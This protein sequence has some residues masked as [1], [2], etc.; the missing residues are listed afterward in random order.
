[1]IGR[2]HGNPQ[3]ISKGKEQKEV[4][5]GQLLV[6]GSLFELQI[7]SSE[8][9]ISQNFFEAT[10]RTAHLLLPGP[11]EKTLPRM[12]ESLPPADYYTL[13]IAA[14]STAQRIEVRGTRKDLK[15]PGLKDLHA[16]GQSWGTLPMR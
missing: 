16:C 15:G 13:K 2:K 6:P 8:E 3:T 10:D 14:L 7:G 4:K 1:M 12:P 9:E 5:P 11:F